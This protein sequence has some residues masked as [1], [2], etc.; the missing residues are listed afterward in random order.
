MK[1]NLYR[2]TWFLFFTFHLLAVSAQTLTQEMVDVRLS[3]VKNKTGR[4]NRN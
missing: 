3:Q 1:I 4:G 2:G